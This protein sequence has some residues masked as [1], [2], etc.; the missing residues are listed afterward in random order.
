MSHSVVSLFAMSRCP[1]CPVDPY[2]SSILSQWCL[3]ELPE[4]FLSYRCSS[5]WN[6]SQKQRQVHVFQVWWLFFLMVVWWGWTY[7]AL[8]SLELEQPF[9]PMWLDR[10]RSRLGAM[11]DYLGPNWIPF[12]IVVVFQSFSPTSS[13]FGPLFHAFLPSPGRSGPF[14]SCACRGRRRLRCVRLVQALPS[15]PPSAGLALCPSVSAFLSPLPFQGLPA[16]G[17]VC[18]CWCLLLP[19]SFAFPSS[20][21]GWVILHLIHFHFHFIFIPLFILIFTSFAWTPPCQRQGV[22]VCVCVYRLNR[23]KTSLMAHSICISYHIILYYTLKQGITGVPGGSV[24]NEDTSPGPVQTYLLGLWSCTW[25]HLSVAAGG[26]HSPID[27]YTI[28]YT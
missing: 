24:I 1:G 21:S 19:S 10:P 2:T 5:G 26:H 16:P 28:I 9:M 11:H 23:R 7:C 3:A 12:L 22:C 17:Q 6:N 20:G 4:T 25:A 13:P 27:I 18:W 15:S 14:G 8:N